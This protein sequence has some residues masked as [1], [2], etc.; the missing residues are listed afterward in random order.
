MKLTK[1]SLLLVGAGPGDPDLITMKGLRAIRSA[2]VILYDAWVSPELLKEASQSCKLVYVGKRRAHKEFSQMEINQLLVFYAERYA[3]VVRLKGGDPFVFGR[4][5]E[6]MEYAAAHGVSVD[7]IPGISSSYSAPS[8]AGIPLTTRG[9]NES[10]WVVTGTISSGGI[11]EDLN[12]AAET[13]ATIIVLMGLS[14]LKEIADLISSTRGQ[15]EPM[16]VIQQATLPTQ[17]V[18]VGTA[19][20]I[21]QRATDENIVSPAIIVI[22]KVVD[23]RLTIESNPD[24]FEKVH[25]GRG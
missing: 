19:A 6:E 22:G 10:F 9:V 14:H 3:R 12:K 20:T 21:Y 7:V 4:G 25:G 1:P 16:A 8:C 11:S 18:I 15:R 23:L 24:I 13:N 5:H 17:K 2:N